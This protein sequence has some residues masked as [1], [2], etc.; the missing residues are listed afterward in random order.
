MTRG[1]HL[2]DFTYNRMIGKLEDER[3]GKNVAQEFEM[4][5]NVASRMWKYFQIRHTFVRSLESGRP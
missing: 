2:D 5:Q 4:N 3:G 1:K